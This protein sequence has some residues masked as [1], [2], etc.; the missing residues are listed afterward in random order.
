MNVTLKLKDELLQEA[1]HRAV[2]QHMSLS[3]WMAMLLEK[4]LHTSS[5]SQATSLAEQLGDERLADAPLDLPSR[6]E[7]LTEIT[8]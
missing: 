8:W 5:R 7:A 3:G 4:E 6:N 2:D 1:R